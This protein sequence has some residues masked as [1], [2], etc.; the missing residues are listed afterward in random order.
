MSSSEIPTTASAAPAVFLS[1]GSPM[2]ALDGGAAG[3]FFQ[4]LGPLWL[5]QY[6]RPRAILV[7]SAHTL[8][9]DWVL[10]GAAAHHAMYD[11]GGFDPRL[12]TLRYDAPGAPELAQEIHAHLAGRGW[13]VRLQAQSGL[14]HGIWTPLRHAWP[15]ADIP[16]L[17]LAWN[18]RTAPA[19]LMRMGADLATLA[20]L[21]VWIWGSGSITHNLQ[22]FMRHPAPMEWPERPESLAFRTWW[23]ERSAAADWAALVDYRSQAPFAELM[24]PTDEHL[25][26]FFVAAGVGAAQGRPGLRLHSSAQHGVIGMDSYAFAQ[27]SD[28]P[29]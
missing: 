27:E 13:R 17:P 7:V 11:F 3:R 21:G 20:Q 25:L 15:A 24:H 26:P 16:I 19:E 14:D 6:G 22:L 28:L 1:H 10:W 23:A 9:H 8:D 4:R 2:T 12:R 18:P 5:Q 29:H